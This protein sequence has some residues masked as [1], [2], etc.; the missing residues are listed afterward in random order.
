ML[1]PG[2]KAPPFSLPDADMEPVNLEDFRGKR[3][4]CFTSIPKTTHPDV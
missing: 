2:D 4:S 3:M 1:Q